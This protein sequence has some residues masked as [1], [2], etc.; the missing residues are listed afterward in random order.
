MSILEGKSNEAYDRIKAVRTH[1]LVVHPP[2][3]YS[4]AGI[5]SD[6]DP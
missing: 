1:A 4:P 6:I 2:H 5:R 3:P